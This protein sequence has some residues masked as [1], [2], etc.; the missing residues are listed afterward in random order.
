MQKNWL[1]N[2]INFISSA[3]FRLIL[4]T[5]L[6]GG[7]TGLAVYQRYSSGTSTTG[8]AAHG[9]GF[10]A[11]ETLFLSAINSKYMFIEVSLRRNV[12]YIQS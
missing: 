9:G 7:D 1:S 2:P 4:M 3:V 8:F 10:V 5:L 6:V 11:G 12:A